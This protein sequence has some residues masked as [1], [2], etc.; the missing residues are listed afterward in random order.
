MTDIRNRVTE[1]MGK[2]NE[3]FPAKKVPCAARKTLDPWPK[4]FACLVGVVVCV[5]VA[6]VSSWSN[7]I[8]RI[9]TDLY[10]ITTPSTAFGYWGR[11][12]SCHT[13]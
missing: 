5:D 12:V 7:K 3:E 8:D 10:I 2:H 11:R 6:A 1:F 4:D 9:V 13:P